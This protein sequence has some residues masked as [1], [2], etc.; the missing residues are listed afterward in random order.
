MSERFCESAF[1]AISVLYFS[2][3][4]G[5]GKTTGLVLRSGGCLQADQN[6]VNLLLEYLPNLPRLPD[7]QVEVPLDGQG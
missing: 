4:G 2:G 1:I 5:R 7:I 6:A 3:E